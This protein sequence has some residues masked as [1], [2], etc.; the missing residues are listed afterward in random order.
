LEGKIRSVLQN[1][2]LLSQAEALIEQ[3]SE[4]LYSNNENLPPFQSGVG[5]HIRH[6]LDF[7]KAF[8]A[9][10]NGTID[11][12]RRERA[13]EV[14]TSRKA[15]LAG[16]KSVCAALETVDDVD[17]PVMSRN[18]DGMGDTEG[19]FNASSI[20][21]ELRFLTSHTV[22][23]FAIIAMILTRQGYDPPKD[24]GVAPSTLAFWRE[25]LVRDGS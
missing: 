19:A 21:R 10:Q 1:I 20:G 5:M 17:Q 8:F 7:Y 2:G 15:A 13:P 16:I 25:S 18:D 9:A 11:Y 14:E 3:L 22:H 12:D 24:F 4:G 6:I 23:H